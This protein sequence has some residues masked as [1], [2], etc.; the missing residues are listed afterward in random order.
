[1]LSE[2][3]CDSETSMVTLNYQL[4]V[5]GPSADRYPDLLGGKIRK[6]FEDLG[7]DPDQNLAVIDHDGAGAFDEHHGSLLCV[8]FGGEA[9]PDQTELAILERLRDAGAPILPLVQNIARF[10]ELVPDVLQPINGL[11]WDDERVPGDALRGF[12]LT[13]NLRQAFISY[14]RA[15]SRCVAEGLFDS[16][17]QRR[18]HVF[19]DTASVE[20]MEPFQDILWDRLAD[21]D[22]LV[23]LDSPDAL[24]SRWVNDELVQVNNLGLGVLQLVWP[25]HVPY[26]G[27]EL[28][29]RVDLEPVDFEDARYGP[30]GRLTEAALERIVAE[31]E[32]VRIAS[33]GA[34]RTRVVGEFI[35]LVPPQ[36]RTDVQPVGPLMLRSSGTAEESDGRP[37]GIVL[38][39]IGFPDAGS[40]HREQLALDDYP[41]EW[42]LDEKTIISLIEQDRVRAIYDGLGIRKERAA[43]LI[44]LNGYLPLKTLP[45]DRSLAASKGSGE[46]G[47]WLAALAAAV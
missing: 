19:L 18:F 14:R 23:L 38:P 28:S 2:L 30:D 46:L 26:K 12:R 47:R 9:K 31:A 27:T 33:L 34:R 37:L 1:M 11:Q 43:H 32:S 3:D 16:L 44:W 7:L 41:P 20:S 42:G 17:S 24:S 8:W 36:L 5:L 39:L 4:I 21:M 22:L 35:T 13:P 15:D 45:L 25:E 6:G 40:L 29:T 10:K